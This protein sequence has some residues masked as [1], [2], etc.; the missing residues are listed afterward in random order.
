MSKIYWI[1]M[2]VAILAGCKQ[3]TAPKKAVA[4]ASIIDSLL[5]AIKNNDFEKFSRQYYATQEVMDDQVFLKTASS[6]KRKQLT[7]AVLEK[8]QKKITKDFERLRDTVKKYKLTL[9][10][11]IENSFKYKSAFRRVLNKREDITREMYFRFVKDSILVSFQLSPM[12][13]KGEQW[14]IN[15]IWEMNISAKKANEKYQKY[16]Y[17]VRTFPQH[18]LDFAQHIYQK[19]KNKDIEGLQQEYIT[20]VELKKILGFSEKSYRRAV[21]YTQKNKEE[22]AREFKRFPAVD[23]LV[24]DKTQV[25]W[26]KKK[27]LYEPDLGIQLHLK[28]TKG[29]KKLRLRCVISDKRISIA[30]FDTKWID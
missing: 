27:R 10:D 14:K 20:N 18:P 16:N 12:H 21:E 9:E 5:T 19:I 24:L 23:S 3:T 26:N 25:I 22:L 17:L 13:L 15:P 1:I 28:T 7:E 11:L 2:L 30:S 6:D 4:P 29:D 8:H